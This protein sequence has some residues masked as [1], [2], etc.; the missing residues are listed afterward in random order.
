MTGDETSVLQRRS[1]DAS[2][3]VSNAPE[4]GFALRH[5]R[6]RRNQPPGE[7]NKKHARHSK[8]KQKNDLRK[9][10]APRAPAPLRAA[11]RDSV[12]ATG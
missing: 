9:R 11:R 10:V 12:C 7:A 6:K 1:T 2:E 4:I 3:A 5:S 8:I